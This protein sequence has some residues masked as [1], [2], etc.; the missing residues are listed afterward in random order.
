MNQGSEDIWSIE[1]GA[2]SLF[3]LLIL[4]GALQQFESA[5]HGPRMGGKVRHRSHPKGLYRIAGPLHLHMFR[6]G[7]L[8]TTFLS[9]DLAMTN[10][11]KPPETKETPP[12][13]QGKGQGS[14]ESKE[15]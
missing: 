3:K 11:N 13:D 2:K 9:E 8:L 15:K 14:K 1:L 5:T 6:A 12:K 10:G 4:T 7:S